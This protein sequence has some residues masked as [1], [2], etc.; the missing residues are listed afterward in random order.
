MPGC[1]IFGNQAIADQCLNNPRRL[2][3]IR[4]FQACRSHGLVNGDSLG[5]A[6]QRRHYP[7]A[8]LAIRSLPTLPT[9][10][11]LGGRETGLCPCAVLA[12][13]T[14]LALGGALRAH[15]RPKLHDRHI[16]T[17]AIHTIFGQ[18]IKRGCELG[19]RRCTAPSKLHPVTHSRKNSANIRIKDGDALVEL[20]GGKSTRG[21]G[22]DPGQGQQGLVAIGNGSTEVAHN[23]LCALAKPQRPRGIAKVCPLDQSLG[24]RSGRKIRRAR[25]QPHPPH[26]N[27]LHARDRGLLAHHLKDQGSPRGDVARAHG[28]LAAMEL[29]PREDRGAK[30]LV[31]W[32][33]HKR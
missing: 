28:E 18:P 32:G 19:A 27:W 14:I 29:V 1:R 20:E 9:R 10:P 22:T 17:S 25:P 8:G 3:G 21:I 12:Q 24:G 6:P 33:W 13:W 23:S 26:P 16:P 2:L 30:H 5:R 31:I 4:T 15:E 11:H 7:A